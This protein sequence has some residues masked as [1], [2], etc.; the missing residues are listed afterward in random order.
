[1]NLNNEEQ[2]D[3][4]HQ[5]AHN[6]LSSGAVGH[7]ALVSAWA[8]RFNLDRLAAG[9]AHI[10]IPEQRAVHIAEFA[11]AVYLEGIQHNALRSAPGEKALAPP[12][13]LDGLADTSLKTRSKPSS[14]MAN[15]NRS[16]RTALS[17]RTGPD[18]KP[19]STG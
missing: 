6:S 8:T 13:T 19:A 18:T 11:K 12:A 15:L 2:I 1:M 17:A 9:L 7:Q 5:V 16:T 10:S 3:A 14:T 4:S